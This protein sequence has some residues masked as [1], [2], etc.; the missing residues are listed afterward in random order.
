MPNG[1]LDF[2]LSLA[3]TRQCTFPD[4]VVSE[5]SSQTKRFKILSLTAI[6][7][8]PSLSQKSLIMPRT[9]KSSN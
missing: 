3:V 1:N 9:R 6:Q 4:E 2:F 7:K 8:C 5:K